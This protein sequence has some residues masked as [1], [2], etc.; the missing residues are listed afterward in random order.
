MVRDLTGQIFGWVTAISIVGRDTQRGAT[1]L[2]RCKCGK[3][4]I[5]ARRQLLSGKTVSCGCFFAR[6]RGG[7]R[8]SPCY[9]TWRSMLQRCRDKNSRSWPHYGGRGIKVCDAW[10][11]FR[12]FERDMGPR[13]PGMSI[14]RIDND[15]NYEPGNCRWATISEQTRN[16]RRNVQ[17]TC[18]GRTQCVTD[19]AEELGI[20]A[21]L[22]YGRLEDGWPAEAALR[23]PKQRIHKRT[24]GARSFFSQQ[25]A[26]N[27]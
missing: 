13:P 21:H 20:D 8:D 4:I 11:D 5:R 7:K 1:W 22:I 25:P 17:L 9:Q 24:R 3:Q 18:H 16:Y 15:G 6:K 2:C 10:K 12:V 14:D 23:L 19:W 27:R 26:D